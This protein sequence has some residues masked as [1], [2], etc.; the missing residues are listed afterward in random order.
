[1]GIIMLK[2]YGHIVIDISVLILFKNTVGG[3]FVV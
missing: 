2:K 3:T 1:M